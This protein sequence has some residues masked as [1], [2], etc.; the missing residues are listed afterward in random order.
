MA[1]AQAHIGTA[2]Y[3]TGGDLQHHL[4]ADEPQRQNGGDDG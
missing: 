2:R 1:V 3:R 4:I